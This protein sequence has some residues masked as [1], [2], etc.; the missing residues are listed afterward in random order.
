[1][2]S[3]TQFVAIWLSGLGV[4][5]NFWLLFRYVRFWKRR[6]VAIR[7][8]LGF[9][10]SSVLFSLFST[11]ALLLPA[12]PILDFLGCMLVYS[13]PMVNTFFILTITTLIDNKKSLLFRL[14]KVIVAVLLALLPLYLT[15]NWHH[16]LVR[17]V[18]KDAAGF[19]FTFRYGPLF[20]GVYAYSFLLSVMAIWYIFRSKNEGLFNQ[21]WIR[22]V[23]VLISCIPSILDALQN[24]VPV[25]REIAIGNMGNWISVALICY[26]FFGYLF[27]ARQTA[28][29]LVGDVYVVF[30][31]NGYCVD[32][33]PGGRAFFERYVG[34]QRPAAA[35]FQALLGTLPRP[36]Q[37]VQEVQ[38]DAD[39]QARYYQL[40]AFNLSSGINQACGVGYVVHEV[41]EYVNRVSQLNTIAIE[42]PLTHAKNRRYLA[43]S[44]S[45]LFQKAME[46]GATF[47]VLMLDIDFFK[48]VNDT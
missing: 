18:E 45:V 27:T 34:V 13:G 47:S 25:L 35:D 38:L 23:L 44:G 21:R 26:L 42:D 10:G 3:A 9:I 16:W 30:D 11:L 8:S 12:G 1:M 14:R 41:T 5:V 33:N 20:Y 28:L 32:I 40:T 2:I 43:V 37:P 19:L 36:G 6:I 29:D 15:N 48:M 31:F 46:D 17:D 22:W 4:F 24:A 7:Y 39:G